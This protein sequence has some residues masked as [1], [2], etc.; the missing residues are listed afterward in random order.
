MAAVWHLR[1]AGKPVRRPARG[2]V[3]GHPAPAR[4][5][6]PIPGMPGD[7]PA[8]V[9]PSR[10]RS[11]P[12][13]YDPD[14]QQ[15]QG[16][17][18]GTSRSSPD[19]G[20]SGS[21]AAR[22]ARLPPTKRSPAKKSASKTPAAA[23]RSPS[24]ELLQLAKDMGVGSGS[25]AAA[26][27]LDTPTRTQICVRYGV[28]KAVK[29]CGKTPV[30]DYHDIAAE[31]GIDE[32]APGK[33]YRKFITHG[34]VGT[35][36][37]SGRPEEWTEE[38]SAEME[39]ML[40]DRRKGHKKRSAA[41]RKLRA[42]SQI[43]NPQTSKPFCHSTYCKKRTAAGFKARARR[44]RPILTKLQR[45]LRLQWCNSNHGR[46]WIQTIR[47]EGGNRYKI[48]HHY[49][50]EHYTDLLEV[51]ARE[52][53]WVD[54]GRWPRSPQ[55]VGYVAN[56]AIFPGVGRDDGVGGWKDADYFDTAADEGNIAGNPERQP[57]RGPGVGTRRRRGAASATTTTADSDSTPPIVVRAGVCVDAP[58]ED[59]DAW[60][61]ALS[62]DSDE[63]Q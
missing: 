18:H 12:S 33:I 29:A 14:A 11:A 19:D 63:E 47:M 52:R 53:N 34:T 27:Y 55:K 6:E 36:A 10:K 62:D 17:R 32:T 28:W 35:R 25:R 7:T 57:Q 24:K 41:G 51:S 15:A 1:P 8:T 61:E 37:K 21:T 13:T 3:E 44:S 38:A 22:A 46:Q 49:D 60:V 43:V 4:P 56:R 48:P 20:G 2:G 9:R 54:S 23:A 45:Q 26:G 42:S 59:F 5:S 40:R 16:K 30:E 39:E 31:F 58:V 50:P